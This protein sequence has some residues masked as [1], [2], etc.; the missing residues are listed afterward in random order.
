VSEVPGFP[1]LRRGA[2]LLQDEQGSWFVA[3]ARRERLDPAEFAVLAQADGLRPLQEL[4]PLVQVHA[5]AGAGP[6]IVQVVEE[7]RRREL[8]EDERP[9]VTH[10]LAVA[11]LDDG[12]EPAFRLRLGERYFAVGLA[13]YLILSRCDGTRTVAQLVRELQ[14]EGAD[15]DERELRH[16]LR[17]LEGQGYLDGRRLEGGSPEPVRRLIYESLLRIRFTAMDT[18]GLM[19]RLHR[20]L[21]WLFSAPALTV[22][23]LIVLAGMGVAALHA[24]E[25][26]R[27]WARMVVNPVTAMRAILLW[28]P[29]GIIHEL[30]HALTLKHFGGRVRSM[31]GMLLYFSPSLFTDISDS[32]LLPRRQRVWVALAGELVDLFWFSLLVLL[33]AAA[34]EGSFARLASFSLALCL[35]WPLLRNLNPGL[36][37]DGMYV[38]QDLLRITNLRSRSFSYLARLVLGPGRASGAEAGTSRREKAWLVGYGL[39]G[40][41]FSGAVLAFLLVEGVEFYRAHFGVAGGVAFGAFMLAVLGWRAVRGA[42]AWFSQK[43]KFHSV[44][45]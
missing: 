32:E 4:E 26:A 40:L 45:G 8:L 22:A 20:R 41:T 3:G 17:E 33:W 16:L 27:G 44:D 43:Y 2:S 19:T 18:D 14:A 34:P 1:R 10:G 9:L 25:L 7:L 5:A 13:E 6:D 37:L 35:V 42:R 30:A 23:G 31:G 36:P 38:L 28:V 12:P 21:R 11:R 24:G 39:V 15:I 29:F